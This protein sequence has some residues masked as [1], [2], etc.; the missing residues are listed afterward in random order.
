MSSRQQPESPPLRPG[1]GEGEPSIHRVLC[2][3]LASLGDTAL[4]KKQIAMQHPNPKPESLRGPC[5]FSQ[6]PR[7]PDAYANLRTSTKEAKF[8]VFMPLS[9]ERLGPTVPS[10]SPTRK[11]GPG[12]GRGGLGETARG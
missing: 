10:Q 11:Q 5:N 8:C 7:D 1:P 3:P 6:R 12:K 2:G 9:S 4:V